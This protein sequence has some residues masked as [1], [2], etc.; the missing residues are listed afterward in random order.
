MTVVTA[1][2]G[3]LCKLALKLA[4]VLAAG[5][6]MAAEDSNDALT[7]LNSFLASW[8]QNRWLIYHLKDVACASTGAKNYTVGPGGD[9]DTARPDSLETAYVRLL[10]DPLPLANPTPPTPVSPTPTP[11]PAA[12]PST[13]PS[14]PTP[15]PPSPPTVTITGITLDNTTTSTPAGS[16]VGNLA[17]QTSGGAFTGT[18]QAFAAPFD[19]TTLSPSFVVTS[20][21]QLVTQ[22]PGQPGQAFVG[23]GTWLIFIEATMSGAT[24]S[25]FAIAATIQVVAPPPT[26]STPP[27]PPVVTITGIT[28]SGNTVGTI[29]GSTVGTVAVQT[30]GGPFSGTLQALASPLTGAASANFFINGIGQLVTQ[31]QGAPG[32][33]FLPAGT[34]NIF[35]QATMSG[36]VASP[37]SIAASIQVA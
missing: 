24:N 12:S 20:S 35:I 15:S 2:A 32:H 3:D 11:T 17:V 30:T 10:A 26:P 8:T 16:L 18:L 21:L 22:A 29:A 31:A 37:F 1:T 9:F 33:A 14:P 34:Y 23:A 6:E 19:G 5:Q 36:A 7:V 27:T 13:P 4:G 25:P 28:L